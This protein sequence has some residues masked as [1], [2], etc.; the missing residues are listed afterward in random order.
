MSAEQSQVVCITGMHRSHT[1]LVASWLES[2]GLVLDDGRSL[3]ARVGNPKGHF[4]DEDFLKLHHAEIEREFPSSNGWMVTRSRPMRPS[5][6]FESSAQKLIAERNA[7][8]PLWGWKDPRT[9]LYLKHWKRWI[10]QMKVVLLWRPCE[11]VVE[12][13]LD[14]ARRDGDYDV[15]TL[16]A[17]GSWRSDTVLIAAGALAGKA[18]EA[19]DLIRSKICPALK[20]RPLGDLIDRS[21]LKTRNGS[22]FTRFVAGLFATG[23]LERELED[24]SDITPGFGPG[25][26][27]QV[28]PA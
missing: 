22:M 12:S 20:P 18:P 19:I 21:L 28:A 2:C 17:V 6:E 4:E 11:E 15:P 3:G 14:R 25:E 5:A 13:L 23:S 1:S 26:S 10:P 27:A 24:A 8:F 16:A 9:S 7:K